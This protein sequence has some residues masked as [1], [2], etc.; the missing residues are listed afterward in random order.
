MGVSGSVGNG[1]LRRVYQATP[2]VSMAFRTSPMPDHVWAI[3]ARTGH[4]I[5]HFKWPSKG[6]IHIGNRGVGVLPV[7][8]VFR[9]TRL[10][11][12]R[13]EYERRERSWHKWIC[14]L[15]QMYFGSSAPLI[16]GNHVITG[17]SGDDLDVPG[18][19]ESHDPETGARQW[20]WYAI[21]SPAIPKRSPGRVSRRC[22]TEAG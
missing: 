14:D 19:I 7:T 3:D 21:L 10:Q 20:R 13:V 12:R 5:W 11:S 9:D 1:R 4:E 2:L 17:V 8:A 16:V 22:C 18:Y 15:D 6:G